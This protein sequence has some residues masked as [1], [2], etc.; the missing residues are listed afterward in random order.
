MAVHIPG[1]GRGGEAAPAVLPALA[2][3]SGIKLRNI[4]IVPQIF[5]FYPVLIC[6]IFSTGRADHLS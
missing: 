5:S 3:C 4:Y 1:Q 6:L 2:G